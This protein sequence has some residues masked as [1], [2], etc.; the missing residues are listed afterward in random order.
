MNNPP[1]L[2]LLADDDEGDTLLFKEA[3]SELKIKS[4]VHTTNNGVELMKYLSVPDIRLP[5]VIFLDLN[6]PMKNGLEC[7]I[8]IKNNDMLKDISIAIYS[9][10]ENEK[11]IEDTFINGANVYITKPN[12]F[13]ILKQVLERAVMTSYQYRDKSMKRENFLLRIG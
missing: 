13:N 6:M 7:L 3:F 5:D 1:I 8:E 12:D 9:T 10:S 2:I 4:I 11:D